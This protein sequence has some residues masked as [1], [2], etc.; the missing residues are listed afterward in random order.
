[1]PEKKL[2]TVL[3]PVFNEAGNV[4]NA[5]ARVLSSF[6]NLEDRYDLEILFTDNHS[7]D[8]TFE[9]LT[10][11]AASDSR[12]RAL[13]FSRNFGFQRSILT[14]Y[15]HARG[16]AAIQLDCDLQDP[17]ELM[18]EF[19][20][21]WEEG[22]KVVYGVRRKRP[23]GPLMLMARKAFY[24]VIDI[25]SE[26]PLPRDAG[27]FRLVDR[28]ILDQLKSLKDAQPYLRGA[29]AGLGFRQ[30]GIIY[31]RDSRNWGSSKFTLGKLTSLAIDGILNHS[32]VPL[33]VATVIGLFF[34]ALSFFGVLAYI[35]AKFYLG[36]DWPAGFTTITI[37]V[38]LTMGLNALFLGII[39][40][41]VG[42]IY[43]QVKRGPNSIIEA[44]LN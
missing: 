14:G 38:L 13:R 24:R 42:R 5:Y 19:V 35:F 23:D 31:D 44:E 1:M 18:E 34:S 40:E 33:R 25:L 27:D 28:R 15:K 21:K 9:I 22:Y 26:T 30:T 39:G 37:L 3:I 4:K 6:R 11:L 12:V 20:E 7:D 29:I 43:K 2:I 8:G 17:P 32:V 10:E 41:Y 36:Q 16:D